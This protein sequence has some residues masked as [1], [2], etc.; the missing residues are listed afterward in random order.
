MVDPRTSTWPDADSAFSVRNKPGSPQIPPASAP[1]FPAR[2]SSK[3]SSVIADHP[4]MK[5]GLTL[6]R[7]ADGPQGYGDPSEL[8]AKAEAST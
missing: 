8:Q 6:F 1:T 5:N 4:K 7:L 3:N 2:N